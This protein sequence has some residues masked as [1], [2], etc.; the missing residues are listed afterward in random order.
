MRL[1][2]KIVRFAITTSMILTQFTE[3]SRAGHTIKC[4]NIVRNM[5]IFDNKMPSIYLEKDFHIDERLKSS[6]YSMEHI[7]PR[8]HM[9]IKHAN[10]MH[11]VIRTINTLNVNRSNYEFVDADMIDAKEKKHWIKLDFGNYVNHKKKQF[12]PN[13]ASRGFIARAILYM[14]REYDYN[15]HKIISKCTLAKWFFEYPPTKEEKYH[16]EVIRKLQNKNNIF[17]SNY[18]KKKSDFAKLIEKL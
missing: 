16:N 14:C 7:F 17:I 8:S 1:F 18:N 15:H 13:S 11:N 4:T 9:S 3:V 6:I 5:I 2:T 10:D 12:I